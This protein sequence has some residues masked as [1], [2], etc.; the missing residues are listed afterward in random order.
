MNRKKVIRFWVAAMLLIL[1]YAINGTSAEAA[2]VS[3]TGQN[4]ASAVGNPNTGDFGAILK[5]VNAAAAGDIIELN[6]TF[7]FADTSGAIPLSRGIRIAKS[8]TIRA[9]ADG[10]RI[11]GP[12]AKSINKLRAT[13]FNIVAGGGSSSVEGITFSDFEVAIIADG[14]V[15]NLTINNN[16]F[17]NML[18]AFFGFNTVG[19]TVS[20]NKISTLGGKEAAFGG[21]VVVLNSNKQDSINTYRENE[22]T[23]P[24]IGKSG[25]SA[26]GIVERIISATPSSPIVDNNKISGFDTG[27][28]IGEVTRFGA[29]NNT[30][31]NCDIALLIADLDPADL[32]DFGVPA[33]LNSGNNGMIS[34][35][36]LLNSAKGLGLLNAEGNTITNNVVESCQVAYLQDVSSMEKPT[37]ANQLLGN[38]FNKNQSDLLN[39]D[40]GFPLSYD[41]NTFDGGS[42]PKLAD[43]SGAIQPSDSSPAPVITSIKTKKKKMIVSGRSL[44]AGS[45]LLI[46][47]NI[48]SVNGK[49][50]AGKL[51][52]GDLIFKVKVKKLGLRVGDRYRLQLLTREGRRSNDFILI[53]NS[54][55]TGADSLLAPTTDAHNNAVRRIN[56]VSFSRP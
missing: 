16:S 10:A 13:A 6:G 29:T 27:M 9:G 52:N 55:V 5:A 39:N 53:L 40:M 32:P 12:G 41:S 44:Q 11:I 30:I 47:G 56:A 25:K 23:G 7:L 48:V 50:V 26:G 24:G 4:T 21:A 22:I 38:T 17:T 35:N 3:V 1:P 37:G 49:P 20:R 8:L 46:D 15:A 43:S 14:P 45:S 51:V 31:A 2:T 36:K 28:D 34:G 19:L 42:V 18:T 33:G 54:L